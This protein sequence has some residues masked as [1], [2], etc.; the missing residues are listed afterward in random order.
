M[1]KRTIE[2][3]TQVI[4]TLLQLTNTTLVS[5]ITLYVYS[6]Q[7]GTERRTYIRKGREK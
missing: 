7:L 2:N 1:V 3:S 6:Q 5:P 4:H